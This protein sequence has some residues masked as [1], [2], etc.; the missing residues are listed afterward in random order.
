MDGTVDLFDIE[1]KQDQM[2]KVTL[3]PDPWQNV[4]IPNGLPANEGI[5]GLQKCVGELS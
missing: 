2:S 3:P 4:T 1:L 5:C